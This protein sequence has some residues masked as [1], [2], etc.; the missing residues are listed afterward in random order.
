MVIKTP[1]AWIEDQLGNAVSAIGSARPEDYWPEDYRPGESRRN[2]MA[3]AATPTVRRIGIADLRAALAQGLADF[4]ASRTD[5]IFICVMYPL[6][7]LLLARAASGYGLL[8]LLF[9]LASGFA[10]VGPL[11][12]V[13]LMEMSWR[14]ERGAAVAWTDAFDVLRAPSIG[15]IAVLGIV[16][17]SL[18]ILW[19]V[20][21]QAIYDHTMGPEKPVSAAAFVTDMFATGGGRTMIVVG[22]AVGFV[23]AAVAFSISVLSF[24]MLL[25]HYIGID[26]AVRTSLRAVAAN[27]V[28]M[29]AWGLIVA[30]LLVLG[31]IPFFVGLVVVLPVLGHA[32]WHLYRL[33]VPRPAAG[34]A[35]T[36]PGQPGTAAGT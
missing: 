9:P 7:G 11:A 17:I 25:D 32:T 1:P 5:V 3:W 21:A 34:Q 18:L 14:R 29:A 4:R 16:L 2:H 28:T 22:V 19:L 10:L 30:A 23:F 6:I 27:P 15:A 35:E 13:G 31:S 24:P 33:L 12:A 8:P 36:A 20:A 26:T